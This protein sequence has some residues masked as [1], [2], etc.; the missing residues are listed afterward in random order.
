VVNLYSTDFYQLASRHLKPKGIVAQWLPL[1]TQNDEDSRSLV[2]SFLDSFPYASVWTTEVQEILL[3]GSPQPLRLDVP[4]ITARFSKP[5]VRSALNE[6]G[7]GSP[8]A[9][10]ATWVTGRE[11]MERYA[12]S[13]PEV[14]DD[15][16]SIE[17]AT[18]VRRGE[19]ARV[20]PKVISLIG[21]AP[22]VG[23]DDSFRSAMSREQTNLRTLYQAELEAFRGDRRGWARDMGVVVGADPE[24]AYYRWLESESQVQLSRDF[25]KQNEKKAGA[26]P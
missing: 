3:L 20:L 17:Y 23:A 24:N 6:V 16:P 1:P 8:A 26:S 14:T 21:A 5:S 12:G 10:L 25:D 2:R 13:A 7:I 9:L 11:G 4:R 18:W 19:I 15:H 22:V